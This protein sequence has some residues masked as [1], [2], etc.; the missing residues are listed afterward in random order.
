MGL[1]A[2]RIAFVII[3]LIPAI[4]CYDKHADHSLRNLAVVDNTD[5]KKVHKLSSYRNTKK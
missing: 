5:I 2:K 3:L 1:Y 4:I